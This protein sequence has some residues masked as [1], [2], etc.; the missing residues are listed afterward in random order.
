[1][2][3]LNAGRYIVAETAVSAAVNTVL[4]VAPAV[5]PAAGPG[6]PGPD[7]HGLAGAVLPLFM[8][9]FM[10]ALVPSLLTRRRQLGGKLRAFLGGGG[11]TVVQVMSVSLLLAGSFTMLGR[12]LADAVPLLTGTGLTGGATLLFKGAYGGLLAALVTPLA[13]LLLFERRRPA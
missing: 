11:P 8:G 7:A 5:L 12:L 4:A 3:R 6:A 10:S 1:M 13:L 2:S 9:A